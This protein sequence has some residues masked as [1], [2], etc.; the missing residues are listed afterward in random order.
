MLGLDPA[1][2]MAQ[3]EQAILARTF[4]NS[5]AL[6]VSESVSGEIDGWCLWY[7]QSAVPAAVESDLTDQTERDQNAT[8]VI[9]SLCFSDRSDL[10]PATELL[11]SVEQSQA[12][13]GARRVL[14]GVYADQRFGLAGLSPIGIGIGVPAHDFRTTSV[15]GQRGYSGQ[16]MFQRMNVSVSGYRPP[17]SREAMQLRRMTEVSRVEYTHP[18]ERSA[19]AMSHLDVDM[20]C[21]VDRSGQVLARVKLWLSDAEAE[22]MNPIMALLDLSTLESDQQLTSAESYLIGIVVQSLVGR[23]IAVVETVVESDR[24][25]LLDQLKSL[26]FVAGDSGILWSKAVA[27]L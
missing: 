26:Q 10:S 7:P 8:G 27:P 14:V 15:L 19:A 2:S 13:Q 25:T 21:L 23:G 3:F 22:V 16:R 9:C 12:R 18:N 5:G 17:I 20:H 6:L 4:F 24:Q 11:N 1:V